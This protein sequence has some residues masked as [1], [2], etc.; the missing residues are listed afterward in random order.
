MVA[1]PRVSPG[2][3]DTE[4]RIS[5]LS[6][7][8]IEKLWYQ[9]FSLGMSRNEFGFKTEGAKSPLLQVY[10]DSLLLQLRS[11]ILANIKER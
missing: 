11:K 3:S 8:T 2:V 4:H 10:C 1:S 5:N 7:G 6:A 9:A